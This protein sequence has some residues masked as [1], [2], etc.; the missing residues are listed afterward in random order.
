MVQI[1]HVVSTDSLGGGGGHLSSKTDDGPRS[2]SENSTEKGQ[3]EPMLGR[4]G[5]QSSGLM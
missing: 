4:R 2:P 1:T 3:E 5:T